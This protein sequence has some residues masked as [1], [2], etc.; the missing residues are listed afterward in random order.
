VTENSPAAAITA[1]QGA[2]A[3][4]LYIAAN[5]FPVLDPETRTIG[6]PNPDWTAALRASARLGHSVELSTLFDFKHGGDVWNGT[7][8]ALYSY[9]THGDTEV[10]ATCTS[11]A[12]SS[13]TGNPMVFGTDLARGPVVGPG[14][15]MAVPIGQNWYQGGLGSGFSAASAQFIEDGSYVKLREIALTFTVPGS[16]ARRFGATGMNLRLAGRN[17]RTWTDYTGIDPETNLTGTSP[18]RGQDYF[19]NPQARQFSVSIGLNR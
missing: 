3:K 12:T 7:R 15:G 16:M 18:L 4:A 14:A 2:D 8:G 5:G 9:G 11:S 1:C 6:D 10:R 19:N 13:C 17:L